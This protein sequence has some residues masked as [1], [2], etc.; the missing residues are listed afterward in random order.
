[1]RVHNH[2]HSQRITHI[3]EIKCIDCIFNRLFIAKCI[4]CVCLCLC[5]CA[6]FYLSSALFSFL[7]LPQSNNIS[8]FFLQLFYSW[9]IFSFHESL[10]IFCLVKL[11]FTG[12]MCTEMY[13]KV[14]DSVSL[15][16]FLSRSHNFTL[17]GQIVG[18]QIDFMTYNSDSI[19][20]LLYRK[21]VCVIECCVVLCFS[22]HVQCPL[23]TISSYVLVLLLVLLLLLRRHNI[24]ARSTWIRHINKCHWFSIYLSISVIHL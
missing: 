10:R 7:V 1:M 3:N 6:D 15:N 8:L 17:A 9:L 5:L 24:Y 16:W 20:R 14:S 13:A 22:F 11:P 21:V 4:V 18:L 19:N 12:M 2:T 23:T